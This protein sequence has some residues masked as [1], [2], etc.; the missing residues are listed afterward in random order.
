MSS[1]AAKVT[2]AGDRI[3]EARAG[4]P[5][6]VNGRGAEFAPKDPAAYAGVY[7]SEELDVSYEIAAREGK[8][9]LTRRKFGTV[10]MTPTVAD[11][12]LAAVN[13]SQALLEFRRSPASPGSR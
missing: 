8:L 1:G 13:N 3:T 12:F 10:P 2:L 5:A 9:C 11:S 6:A 7:R 4:S